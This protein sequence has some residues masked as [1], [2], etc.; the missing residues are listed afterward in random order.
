MMYIVYGMSG[1]P[2]GH[3]ICN[4]IN[5]T[6]NLETAREICFHILSNNRVPNLY[7]FDER[8]N[9]ENYYSVVTSD[10]REFDEVSIDEYS[11]GGFVIHQVE[12]RDT[13]SSAEMDQMAKSSKY[14]FFGVF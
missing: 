5:T 14:F 12:P 6:T 8:M 10:L 1:A 7:P 9:A 3:F 11:F 4:Y 13:F 2:E